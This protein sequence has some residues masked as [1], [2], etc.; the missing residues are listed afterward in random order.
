MPGQ[1]PAPGPGPN[2]GGNAAVALDPYAALRPPEGRTFDL[3]PM[4]DAQPIANVKRGGF[5]ATMIIGLLLAGAGLVLGGGFGTTVSA[6]RAFNAT[7]HAAKQVA[8]ELQEMQKTV[9]QIETAVVSGMHR[10]NAEKRHPLSYDP[11]VIEDLEKVRLDPRPDTS[12]IFRVDYSRMS[13]LAVDNLMSYYYDTIALYNEVERHVKKSK[14]DAAS[15]AAFA[16]KQGEKAQVNYGVV[17]A[18]GGKMVIANLVEMGQPVCKGGGV[19]C[20]VDQLEGFQ[21]RGAAGSAWSTRKVGQKPDGGIL[22]PLDR[23]P[24]FESVMAGSPDQARMEQ[25][26]G[27]YENLRVLLTR[28]KQTQKPLVDAVNAAAARPDMFSL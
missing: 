23:T 5:R 28:L 20:P 17:F 9:T 19:D 18:G 8:T 7:N 25:F 26:R 3:R 1:R 22:V 11:K 12:R 6:R 27:R 24:L 14:A 2:F 10:A 15:L 13:D 4:E 21:I 16:Q